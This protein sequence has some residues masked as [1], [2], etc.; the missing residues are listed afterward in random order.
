MNDRRILNQ[1][2]QPLH[3]EGDFSVTL[4]DFFC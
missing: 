2:I 3:P 4:D 1:T